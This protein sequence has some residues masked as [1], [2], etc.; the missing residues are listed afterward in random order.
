MIQ[1]LKKHLS[2]LLDCLLVALMAYSLSV[3]PLETSGLL[4]IVEEDH[5]K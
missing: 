4:G 3:S 2:Q 5:T 1:P